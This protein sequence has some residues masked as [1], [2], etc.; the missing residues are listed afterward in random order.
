[1]NVIAVGNIALVG[2]TGDV[3]KAALQR[4]GELVRGGF[5]RRAVQAEIDV[6]FSFPFRT[7]IVHLLH[8][9]HGK[10]RCLRIGVTLARHV[11]YALIQTGISQADGGIATIQKLV[12]GLTLFQ[13][14]KRTVLPQN[15]S[16]IGKGSLQAIVTAHQRLPAK[17]KTLFEDA[18]ELV[19]VAIRR[20]SNVYQID[21]NDALVEAAIVLGLARFVVSCV[22]H[23]AISVARTIGSQ[24]GAAT[25]AGVT[26]AVARG[27]TLGKLQFS[28]L[29]LRDVVG[30]HTLCRAFSS[31]LGKVEV[32]GILGDVVF[33]QHVDELRERR[34]DPHALFVLYAFIALTQHFFNDDGKVVL[35]LLRT[36]L[37]Q[38][39]EYGNERSLA[40]GGHKRYHLILDGLNATTNLIAQTA[41]N[42]TRKL[43]S[44]RFYAN[45]IKLADY[46]ATNLLTADLDKRSKMRKRNRLAAVL[47]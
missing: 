26:I 44:G 30:N 9:G 1:M 21:G 6:G 41:F 45:L 34:G 5:E 31:K 8:N 36:R 11:L 23:I 16:R 37:V 13:A 20:A 46:I 15:R 35:L 47:A 25:H 33:L 29:L 28:H 10:R 40:I 4:L 2:N 39:H 24:E 22:C 17:L 3:A 19:H 43:L 32:R 18:P 14:S 42:N 38:V 7:F 12:D 27:F